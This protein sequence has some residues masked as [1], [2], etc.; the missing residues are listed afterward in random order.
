VKRERV[1]RVE[2]KDK[3][4]PTDKRILIGQGQ[5][6]REKK[7]K[8]RKKEKKKKRKKRWAEGGGSEEA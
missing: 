6:R 5:P 7:K 1:G 2:R 4:E 3:E 8:K